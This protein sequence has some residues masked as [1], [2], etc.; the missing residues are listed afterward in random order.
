MTEQTDKTAG[1]GALDWLWLGAALLLVVGGLVAYY[2]LTTLPTVVRGIAVL[3]GVALGAGAFAMSSLGHGVWQFAR[4]SQVEIR[5]MVWPTLTETRTMTFIVFG[6]VVVAG[7]LFW[8]IDAFLAW[9]TRHLLGT[10][11]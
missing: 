9:A 3:A 5:K 10:G 6:F 7:L 1:G 4:G 8:G 11:T 2:S